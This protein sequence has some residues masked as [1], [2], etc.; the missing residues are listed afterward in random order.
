MDRL[1][2]YRAKLVLFPKNKKK[3]LK[4]EAT[5]EEIKMA[6]QFRGKTIMPLPKHKFTLEEDQV[7]DPKIAKMNIVSIAKQVCICR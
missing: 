5:E 2:E 3:T 7:I 4:G 6:Q 1:K